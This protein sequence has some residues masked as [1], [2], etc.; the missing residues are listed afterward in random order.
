M[1]FPAFFLLLSFPVLLSAQEPQ[2]QQSEN[3]RLRRLPDGRL[4]RDAITKENYVKNL[5]DAREMARLAE[6]LKAE[7]EKDGEFV[8]SI[9]SLKKAEEIEKL[10]RRVRERLKRAN[11]P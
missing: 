11:A 3:P 9:G 1:N 6:A 8:L 10:A 5:A 2:A 4:Q 7:V